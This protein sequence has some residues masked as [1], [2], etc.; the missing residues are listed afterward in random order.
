MASFNHNL[1]SL[2]TDG[3]VILPNQ[4]SSE[5]HKSLRLA[6]RR[7]RKKSWP[8]VRTVGK[9]FPPWPDASTANDVWGIQHILHPDISERAFEG[10]YASDAILDT[11]EAILGVKEEE[12]QLELCNML[13]NPENT[14][15]E[16]SWHRDAIPADATEE[17]ETEMLKTPNFGT[18][19]NTALVDDECLEV[20]PGSHRR[21]R[22][23]AERNGQIEGIKVVLKAG[24][25]VFYDHNILHRAVYPTRP[26]RLTLHACMGSTRADNQRRKTILQHGM[27]WVKETEFENPRL[28]SLRKRLVVLEPEAVGYTLVG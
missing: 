3:Y 9:Q 2:K 24:D 16:L 22:T 19:W 20:V 25:S 26:E 23:E 12:L 15:F 7:T 17:E 27:G 11:V 14:S 10:W 28:E 5:L 1:D 8:H 18:Q 4:L 21:V 13:V 6:A